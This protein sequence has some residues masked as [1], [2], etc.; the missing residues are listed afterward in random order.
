MNINDCKKL[1]LGRGSVWL[2]LVIA[3]TLLLAGSR[4]AA[5][6]TLTTLG[7]GNPNVTPKYLGYKDGATLTNALFHTPYGIALDGIYN[8]LYVADRDNNAIRQLDLTGGYTY[9]FAPTNLTIKPVGVAVDSEGNVYV[10]NRGSTNNV[11]TNGSVLTFDTYGDLLATNATKLTNAAGIAIDLVGNIYVTVQSNTLVRILPSGAQ[12]IIATIT[13]A[14][15]SLQGI[16]VKHNGLI[17]ACDSGRNGIYLIDPSTGIVTTNAGFNGRGDGT[18]NGNH[19][20]L[21]ANALFNQPTSLAEAGD[22]SLI[23]TDTGNNRVKVITS[24]IVTNLY[25][26]SSNYWTGSYPG[27]T[28]GTVKVPD[29]LTPN[30]QSRLPVGVAFG[31]DG[32]IYTTED[33]YHLIR[34]VTGAG[35]PLP[36]PLPTQVATP[37]IGYVDFPATALPIP[38]TS[39]FHAGSSFVFNNDVPI[40]IPATAGTQVYYTLGATSALGSIPDPNAGSASALAGYADGLSSNSVSPYNVA[41]PAPDFTIKAIAEK[42]DGSPNSAVAETRFQFVTANP[43]INGNNAAQFTNNDVTTGAL[44]YYTINGTDIINT[45]DGIGPITNGQVLGFSITS[46]MTFKIR[47]FR[48]NYQPSAEIVYVFTTANYA[49]NNISFGFASGEASSAF[50]AAPGQTFYAPVTLSILPGTVMYSLQFNLTVTNGGAVTNPGPAFSGGFGFQSMLEKPQTP[51]PTNFPPGFALYTPIPP[52][53]FDGSQLISGLVT[54]N[55]YNLLGVGW[56]ERYSETNLYNTLAQDLITYSQAHDDQFSQASGKVIVGG[57]SFQVP[58]NAEA[59]QQYQIQIGRPSAT[60]DGVGTP[61]SA[62]Y[63]ATPTNGSLTAGPINSIKVVTI[64]QIKYL[65]GDVYPFSWFN[66]GDFGKGY[67]NNADVE[68]VFQSAVYSLNYPP[69]GSDFFDA[70]DSCGD[71]Y[72]DNGNGYLEQSSLAS[73]NTLFDGNDLTINQI[74]FGD[75]TL[76][77][78][79]VYV[80]FR[81]SLDPSLNWFQ[82]Y[83]TNGVRVASIVPN[84]VPQSAAKSAVTVHSKASV[85]PMSTNA[86]QV[87]FSASNIL[88]SAGQ[89]IQVPI[90]AQIFGAYPLRVLMLNLSVVPLD[91]SPALTTAVSFTPNTALGTPT[92]TDSQGG[93]GNYAATWLNSAI[94]GLSGNVTLGTLTV[95]IPASASKI[96][97]YAVHFDH[98]SASPNGLASFPKQVLTGLITLSSRTNSSYHDG[99][100]DAWRLQWFG[101][102]NDLLSVSNACP[103]SDGISNWKKYIAGVDPT[104]ANDFPSVNARMPIPAG[105]SSAIHWPTVSGKKYVIERS[106]TL[107]G[108]T[109]SAIGTNTGTGTD[110]EFDD[111]NS[112]KVKFYRVKILP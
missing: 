57:Y 3:A 49:P 59:G 46:N 36:P 39:V 11:S 21:K 106:T 80:T 66:A 26:V 60:S 94:T 67:L 91:G 13:N 29:S 1:W 110:M 78:C 108:G 75:G 56:A 112:S 85:T 4:L 38:Y 71:T 69:P 92:F 58:G 5:S 53:M 100:P 2:G 15:T 24:T 96:A 64:G 55:S 47:A 52:A 40:V 20:V 104:V 70:M 68:Q 72:V 23:V 88:A 22:G 7:G 76:D 6:P 8:F 61:G 42:N 111:T 19:G 51:I 86:P 97:A 12:T 81:R 107:F 105:S 18:G 109:W 102:T 99:I 87:N 41:S 95:T 74:G 34:K 43:V 54:N 62:V 84:V 83:W 10:V 25:G 65:A 9:T 82:R 93:Y 101:T 63:I 30:V 89:T 32:T 48:A 44:M 73:T 79:D 98:A 35:L 90:N 77:V 16:V 14:G 27:W 37:Q 50:I 45:S 33:Y 17:A 103:T 28:D 31:N